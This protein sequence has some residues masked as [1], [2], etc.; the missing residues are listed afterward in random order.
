MF[1]RRPAN[2]AR[3]ARHVDM[4]PEDFDVTDNRKW[5]RLWHTVARPSGQR[6]ANRQIFVRAGTPDPILYVEEPGAQGGC[7]CILGDAS[8]VPFA[9]PGD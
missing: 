7:L 5:T 2:D 9:P 1:T 4:S 6:M 8:L 3:S